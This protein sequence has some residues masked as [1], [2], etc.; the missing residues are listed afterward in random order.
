MNRYLSA[1]P[2][3]SICASGCFSTTLPTRRVSDKMWQAGKQGSYPNFWG[4]IPSGGTRGA[5]QLPIVSGSWGWFPVEPFPCPSGR[6][7]N[8]AFP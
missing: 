4:A 2:I 3:T 6:V 8:I 5:W 7:S 1:P